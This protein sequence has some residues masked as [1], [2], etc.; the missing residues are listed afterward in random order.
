MRSDFW[1]ISKKPPK[2]GGFLLQ[3]G[4]QGFKLNKFHAQIV[5][6]FS[7]G[8]KPHPRTPPRCGMASPNASLSL[9]MAMRT[10]PEGE[11]EKRWKSTSES[12]RLVYLDPLL[13]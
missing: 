6:G 10:S 2:V 13:L 11:G 4:E 3:F 1:G 12:R 5:A 9:G 8:V 7:A